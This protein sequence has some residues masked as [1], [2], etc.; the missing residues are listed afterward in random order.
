[1]KFLNKNFVHLHT[2][3]EK[4]SFDGLCKI[5]NLV[6]EARKMG[7]PALAITDH[8][9]LMGWIE[10]IKECQAT[11]DK[12]DKDIPYPPIKPILG[13]ELYF[14]K[15]MNIG[16]YEDKARNKLPKQLQ[17]SGRKG[18][19]HITLYAKNFEGYQNICILS[20]KAWTEGFYYDPR[21]DLD[22]LSKHSKGVIMG[23]ACLKGLINN[24]LYKKGYEP[25]KEAC[26]V[27]KE[28][29]GEDFFLE[30]M[31]H[32]ILA[33][34]AIIPNIFKL[35][36]ELDIP[37]CATND[38][39]YVKKNQA[40]AQEVLMCMNGSRSMKDPNHRTYPY[41]EFY[42][43]SAAEMG[44]I[45]GK[46]PECLYNTFHISERIDTDNIVKNLFGGMR[47]PKFNIP[48]EYKDQYDYLCF[49]AK[50]G[51]KEIGWDKSKEH[52]EALKMELEDVKVARDNNNY[53]FS[54]YFLI[55]RDYIKKAKEMGALIAPG[56]GSGYASV[57]L[58]CLGITYG[59]D[60]LKY[61]FLW[62][63]FLGFSPRQ[64]ILPSDFGFLSKKGLLSSTFIELSEIRK[65]II[66]EITSKHSHNIDIIKKVNEE[67][68]I[69]E[70]TEGINDVN[71]LES[72]FNIW[73]ENKN[74]KGNRNVINS[75]IAYYLDLISEK[76]EGEFLPLR[77][78]FARDGFPDIDSDFDDEK[79]DK[80][81]EYIIDKYGR[82]D[83]GNIGTHGVLKFKSCITRIAKVFDVADAYHKGKD[84]Y[85]TD[86][87]KKVDEILEPFPKKGLQKVRD[88]TGKTHII[89]SLKDAYR[90]CEEFKYHMNK[91]PD[92][93]KNAIEIEG[94]FANFGSHPAGL[95]ISDIP[96]SDIAPLRT[97]KKGVLATQYTMEQLEDIGLIK[98]DVLAISTLT[99]IKKTLKMIKENYNLDVN[100]E[101]LPL[102]D[103]ATF[104]L[105][106]SGNLD[107][108]FQCESWP[109]QETVKTMKADNIDDI[110]AAIS[111]YRPGPMD[112]IPEYCARK[113]GFSKLDY[114]HPSIEKFVKPILEKTYSIIIY[115]EQI[116]QICHALAGFSIADGYVMIKAIGKKKKHLMEKYEKRFIEGAIKKEVPK[117]VIKEYWDKRI[118]P[119]A[120]Y[121]FNL[122][123][124]GAYAMTS[125][126]TCYLKA[127]YSDEFICSLLSVEAE[128]A[129]WDKV[130]SFEKSFKKKMNINILPRN[131]NDCGI[132]YAIE[133]KKDVLSGVNKTEIRP[134]FLCKGVGL[135]VSE[136][137]KEN[138]P[139]ENL[140]DFAKRTSFSIVDTRVVAALCESGYFGEKGKRN[141]EKI[142]ENFSK[143]RQDIKNANKKGLE[144]VDIFE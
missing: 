142:V 92:V 51:L 76:P 140:Q 120:S 119:F 40:T 67:L 32:G 133:K 123:H 68:D 128:R 27:F 94:I 63:R 139:Y 98:F 56:R 59:L 47:L 86:N 134:G 29:F 7:F 66:K 111:L 21:I 107:G 125:Y 84:A 23:S 4:S 129:H 116:Q 91:H 105:Y 90:Y 12:K 77:R 33:Q 48:E 38:I 141:Q 46:K 16:Q 14:S 2:H 121:G 41:P 143:I 132:N 126:I 9:N 64:F 93:F 127:N 52:V 22:L 144:S 8:G 124:A 75:W 44:Q 65:I 3:S 26:K 97:A 45:F 74:K 130:E 100:I 95:V 18:N 1:M 135:A 71:N 19:K 122:A 88:K 54:T 112:N 10:F 115:Q 55:V 13:I 49:L 85:I 138:Q 28:I 60:P 53:D 11:K 58:R 6:L 78:A 117:D 82:E 24:L 109:M 81:Y 99:V 106:K 89:N 37:V 36:S 114:F 80:V 50:K 39:H 101:N 70:I 102:D 43:K 104:E 62:D 136:N 110:M 31:Y 96:L 69:L 17:P 42:L 113:E 87:K 79:R 118:V 25:A 83:V 35:S 137:I 5:P 108:V 61:G 34:R 72:F 57:L 15:Q 131:L 20:Q 30:V 73:Q 103:K